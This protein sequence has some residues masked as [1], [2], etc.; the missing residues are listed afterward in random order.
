MP[1]FTLVADML[2]PDR[3][4]RLLLQTATEHYMHVASPAIRVL[5]GLGM[6]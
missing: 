1:R 4:R 6:S 5:P 2:V 3:W